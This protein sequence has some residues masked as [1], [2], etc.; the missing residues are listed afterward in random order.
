MVRWV[1][2]LVVVAGFWGDGFSGDNWGSGWEECCLC[3]GFGPCGSCEIRCMRRIHVVCTV[4]AVKL[5]GCVELSS[6]ILR[7]FK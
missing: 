5:E 4:C 2:Q 3:L 1:G 7:P 6:L